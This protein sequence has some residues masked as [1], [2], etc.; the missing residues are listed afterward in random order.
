MGLAVLNLAVVACSSTSLKKAGDAASAPDL[1]VADWAARD[2]CASLAGPD[3][4]G[5][6]LACDV[7]F[8]DTYVGKDALIMADVLA[9]KDLPSLKRLG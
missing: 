7:P 8:P 1:G 6:D 9:S 3:L 4:A 5:P 2:G